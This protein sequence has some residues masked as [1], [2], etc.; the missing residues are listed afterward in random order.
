[1]PCAKPREHKGDALDVGLGEVRQLDAHA[2]RNPTD[3]AS[4]HFGQ[5][6]V[7]G[8]PWQQRGK[9]EAAGVRRVN[10]IACQLLQ[11]ELYSPNLL[12]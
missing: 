8:D 11:E 9:A 10:V 6:H 5:E 4:G 2:L 12:R 1:M 3:L 7:V